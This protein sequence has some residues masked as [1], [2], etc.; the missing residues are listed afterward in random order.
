MVVLATALA[1]SLR[2]VRRKVTGTAARPM[3]PQAQNAHWK[4]LGSAAAGMAPWCSRGG[5]GGAAVGEA[6]ATPVPPPIMAMPAAITS[7]AEP[8]VTSACDR[9]AKATEVS[10][11]A[12]Q[13]RPALS[14]E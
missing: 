1:S 6:V 10:D 2:R 7:L 8:R 12:S 5:A 3:A 4:P 13:A 9:P 11:A 14:A